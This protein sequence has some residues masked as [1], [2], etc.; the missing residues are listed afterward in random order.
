MNFIKTA[1]EGLLIIEPQIWKDSR[2]HFLETYN[3]DT[4][5]KNGIEEHFLQ[6]NQ[7]LSSKGTV[8][9]LHAQAG[10]N[11]Q[12]KLVRVIKGCVIDVAVD[13]RKNSSTYGQVFQI[14]L[15]ER[16]AKML[17]IPVG[18]LHGFLSLEDNTIFSYKVTGKY[19]KTHEF[20]VRYNDPA[21]AIHWSLPENELII[22]EKDRALPLLKDIGQ[23]F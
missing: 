11:A 16:N 20:G 10:P 13:I 8:R 22:S 6:D 18:F 4:F 7:S 9:G 19:D 5:K 14:E 15:S 12:G 1:I 23:P 21:L 17:W 3:E 2:G